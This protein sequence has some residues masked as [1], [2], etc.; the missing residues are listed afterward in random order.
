MSIRDS[1]P[2]HRWL[3]AEDDSLEVLGPSPALGAVAA[4]AAAGM[5]YCLATRG[6]ASEGHGA[7]AEAI[8]AQALTQ[9]PVLEV[10]GPSP[11]LG[12]EATTAA[13]GMRHCL[14]T[15]GNASERSRKTGFAKNCSGK[16]AVTPCELC[17]LCALRT[18]HDSDGVLV[19][20]SHL[21]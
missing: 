16:L 2:Q 9:T 6:T 15:R 3:R 14:A 5:R 13:A 19:D 4:T 12:A 17:K 8:A 7:A 20:I 1:M 21:N 11:A 10:L 18:A